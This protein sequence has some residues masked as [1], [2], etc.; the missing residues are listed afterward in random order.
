MMCRRR[1]TIKCITCYA[2]TLPALLNAFARI[3]HQEGHAVTC[4]HPPVGREPSDATG[5]TTRARRG[6]SAL[7]SLVNC[8]SN[9]AALLS[10]RT[11]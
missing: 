2:A 6:A 9:P 8:A 5:A 10:M 3:E 1:P 11:Y 7:P 4:S